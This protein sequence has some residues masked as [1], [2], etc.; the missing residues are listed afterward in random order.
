M[1][2][3]SKPTPL[4]GT[5]ILVL[6][7][8]IFMTVYLSAHFSRQYSSGLVQEKVDLFMKSDKQEIRLVELFPWEWEFMCV[9]GD[10][11]S[12]YAFETAL[13][14]DATVG[15]SLIWYWYGSWFM[16]VEGV[17]NLIFEHNGRI[18]IF[19]YNFFGKQPFYLHQTV[20]SKGKCVRNS[21]TIFVVKD[22]RESG[23]VTSLTV[24]EHK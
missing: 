10:Y 14:R 23:V 24:I 21:K 4:V 17:D 15:E 16:F 12:K 20:V 8:V 3:I 1:K 2:N 5:L 11:A 13:G 18:N 7:M 6:V 22:V 19:Q 9:T